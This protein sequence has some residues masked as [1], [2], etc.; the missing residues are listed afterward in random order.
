MFFKL[1]DCFYVS[2][3]CLESSN[4]VTVESYSNHFDDYLEDEFLFSVTF[5]ITITNG[6][7]SCNDPIKGR[8]VVAIII[9]ILDSS[10]V[11]IVDPAILVDQHLLVANEHPYAGEEVRHFE[12]KHY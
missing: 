9:K 1:I 6:S 8:D 3:E 2:K 12:E 4:H 7:E 5:D 10:H 11:V